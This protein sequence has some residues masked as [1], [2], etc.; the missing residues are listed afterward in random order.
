M[1]QGGTKGKIIGMKNV[2][3][4][5]P[6]IYAK[7]NLKSNKWKKNISKGQGDSLINL[8]KYLNGLN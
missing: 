6:D 7:M 2:R 5:T 1:Y 8:N 4:E 3:H